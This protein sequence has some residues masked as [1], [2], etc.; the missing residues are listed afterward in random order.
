MTTLGGSTC[1]PANGTPLTLAD[2]DHPVDQTPRPSD[3]VDA[4]PAAW[5]AP[6]PAAPVDAT[7]VLPGSK[8]IT[9]RFLVLA[10]LANDT[11][12]IRRPLRSRDTL[13]MAQA[14][15]DLGVEVRD[16]EGDE[17][18]CPDW[19]VEPAPLH[20]PAT[21]DCGLA[22]TIM[23]FL[24]PLAT[25]ADGPVVVDGDP[26]ARTR[27]VGPVLE[28]LRA[29]QREQVVADELRLAVSAVARARQRV[30]VTA[31]EDEQN[32]PSALFDALEALVAEPWIDAETL[33]RDPGPAPDARRLVAA[34]RRRLQSE[35][36]QQVHDAAL[37]L[38]ALGRAGAPGADPARWYHQEPSSA[39]PLHEEGTSI[40]LP[41]IDVVWLGHATVTL[42][43]GGTRLLTD[44][45]VRRHAGLLRRWGSLPDPSDWCDTS[46]VLLSHLHHDHADT[47]SLRMVRPGLVLTGEPNARWVSH[48]VGVPAFGLREPVD[49]AVAWHE[50]TSPQGDDV[51]VALVR[52][53]HHSRPMPHRPN[54]AG[55]FIVRG[56]FGR[57]WFAGDTSL[58]DEMAEL[59]EIAGGDIDLALVPIAGWGPRLSAGHLNPERAALAA[60][61]VGARHVLPIHFGTLQPAGTQVAS[62]RWMV[63]PLADFRAALQLHAPRSRL[64]LPP[65]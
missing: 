26:H 31:V 53:D 13:L 32:E 14:L 16:H 34:L 52:A 38:T 59:P 24:P 63:Q 11:S 65:E 58:Y 33:R 55:G 28:A 27:P 20:G 37:A 22:G 17:P 44:P 40:R 64:L 60:R 39:E 51:E 41:G 43:I 30:L 12:R 6:T 9:N 36:P 5:P 7:A 15:R 57:C 19:I 47:A 3:T 42:D 61:A 48:R 45:L 4:T 54:H 49:S 56:E 2:P 1:T 50:V 25:L 46:A 10:A 21:I 8:S 35:D 29:L 23:R 18:G 62:R